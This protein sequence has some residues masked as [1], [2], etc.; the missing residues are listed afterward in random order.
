M[1]TRSKSHLGERELVEGNPETGSKRTFPKIMS[2]PRGEEEGHG[3][4]E[5]SVITDTEFLEAFISMKNMVEMF[6]EECA[7]KKKEDETSSKDVEVKS[8]EKGK[9]VGDG[10]LNDANKSSSS[11]TSHL[12]NANMSY[13]KLNVKFELPIYNGDLDAEK[14]DNWIKHL[15]FYCRVQGINDDPSRIQLATL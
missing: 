14:L 13:F 9:G 3:E 10:D 5:K 8:E 15:E 11:H 12:N 6:F 2:S 1:L 7:E 4:R